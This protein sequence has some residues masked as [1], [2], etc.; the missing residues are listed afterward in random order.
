MFHFYIVWIT[1]FATP[2][3]SMSF[4]S[5]RSKPS[6]PVIE[7]IIRISNSC[8]QMDVSWVIGVPQKNHPNFSIAIS[9]I[10][11]PAMGYVDFRKPPWNYP[12]N[13]GKKL[14]Q[15]AAQWDYAAPHFP[16]QK[17]A[18]SSPVIPKRFRYGSFYFVLN[19]AWSNWLIQV[20]SVPSLK[21]LNIRG[22]W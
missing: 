9:I 5:N 12:K 6:N 21:C 4:F 10:T 15:P 1:K 19:Y 16:P 7:D 14:C 13:Q 18:W 2:R 22:K 11:H 8:L 20:S 17:L 3:K